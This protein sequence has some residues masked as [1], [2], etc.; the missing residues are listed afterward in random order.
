[1]LSSTFT[2]DQTGQMLSETDPCGNETCTDV[3][4]SSHTTTYSYTDSPVGG[5]APG[6][7]NAYVTKVTRPTTSNIAHTSSYQYSYASGELA[8]STDENSQTTTYLY[9]DP[10][11]RLTDIYGPPSPQNN[12][13]KPHTQYMYTDG[14]GASVT[15][16]NPTN[17]VS[18]SLLDGLGRATET[19]LTKD[20]SGADY[21]DTTYDGMGQ[22]YTVS[23]SYRGQSNLCGSKPDPTC[24][25]TTYSY[26]P[27]GRTT[28]L[29]HPDGSSAITSYSGNTTQLTDEVGN[30]WTQTED[31]LGRL[32]NVAEPGGL[33]TG[34]TYDALG[35]LLTVNQHGTATETPRMRSF[36]YDSLSRLHCASN[37]ENSQ[38]PCPASAATALPVGVTS[39]I[40]DANGNLTS[41]TDGR[42][43]TTGYTYDALNR[44]TT[45]SS[46]G[47]SG[48]PGF[49]YLYGYD[50]ISSGTVQNGIGHL[51]FTT[52]SPGTRAGVAGQYFYDSMGRMTSSTTYLPSAPST[53]VTVSAGYDLAGNETSLTYPDGRKVS[54]VIDG[55]GR[56]SSVNYAAWN[57]TAHTGAYLAVANPG[58]YDAA[59]HLV[60]ATL[61]NGVGIGAGYDNRERISQLVYGSISQMLWGKQYQWTKSSNL[62]SLTDGITGV[63]R[64]FSYD[65]LN[66]LT[67]AQDILGST[68]ETTPPPPSSG[69][70]SG[71]DGSGGATPTPS[72]TDPDDSNVLIDPE[73]PG[74]TGWILNA[75][76][77]VGNIA[78]PDGTT[79]AY[80][81]TASSGSGDSWINDSVTDAYQYTGETMTGSV[82]LRVPNGTQTVNLYLIETGGA[83]G[84]GVS[85]WKP[86]TVTTSWQQFQVSGQFQQGFTGLLLQVG[87]GGTLTSGKTVSL[88]GAMMEDTG[89]TG[90]DVTNFLP[91]SQ[92]FAPWVS[93][94]ITP[95]DNTAIAPDGTNTAATLT[96]S[97]GSTDSHI[98][99]V[100]PNPAAFS[101]QPVTG[102]VWMRSVAGPQN[103]L[104]TLFE[105]GAGDAPGGYSTI[106]SN[107]MA[108]T[109]NWQRF[110]VTGTTLNA[111]TEFLFQIGG[112]GTFTSGSIQVWGA[113]LELAST[114]GP[115]VAT[116]ATAVSTG[117]NLTNLLPY[118][119]QLNGPSWG[120]SSGSI[121]LNAGAAP[122]GTNTAA[123]VTAA[124]GSPDT[125]V[126]D[127]V[128][129]PALYNSQTVTASVYLRV[130]SGTQNLNLYLINV[131]TSSSGPVAMT[132]VT[133]TTTWQRFQVTGTNQNG[134]TRLYLQIGG[135]GTITSGE[136]Y[137]VWGAQIQ[138]GSTVGPYV[139]TSALPVT[140]G[141]DLTNILPNSDG[142]NGPAWSVAN[143]SAAANTATA[144]DGTNTA[145]TLTAAGNSSDTYTLATVPNPSLYDGETVTVSLYARVA[146]GT[147][148]MPLFILNTG[149]N[150]WTAAAETPITLTTTWQRFSVTGTLQNGLT[151]LYMQLGG[152]GAVTSGKSFQVW[153]AQLVVGSDPAPY[154][155]TSSGT[156]NVATS[157]PATLAPNGLNESYSYD[158]F[159]NI[160]QKGSFTA[161][162]TA[163][164]QLV[165]GVYDAA[166]NL[167]SNY[168]SPMTWDAENRLISVGGATYVYDANGN[169]V[170]KQGVGVTDTVYFGGRPVARLSAG[171]WTDLIYGPNGMLGE[172]AGTE[173][174]DTSYRLLDNLG[175]EVGTV[176]STGILTNPLDYT[177]FGQVFSG[178]TNDPYLFTGKERDAESGLDYFGARYYGSSMGRFMSPDWAAQAQPVPYSNLEYPQTLNLY[179][180]AG[181]NPLS[182]SDP[183]GHTWEE[184]GNLVKWGHY[185]NN[186][187]L[188][189][190]LQSDADEARKNISGYTNLSVNGKSPADALK[191]LNN[192]QT[193]NLDRS[194]TNFFEN[195]MMSSGRTQLALAIAT[196]GAEGVEAELA[197]A[198]GSTSSYIINTAKG[199]L[200]KDVTTNVTAAEFGANLEASGFTKTVA[201][202]GVTSLY[203]KGEQT[204]SVYGNS[205]STGGPSANLNV[206]GKIIT[207]I[208]LQ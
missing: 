50:S 98:E 132:A 188:E 32:T 177:P 90:S 45:K 143:G 133:M 158:S 131:G 137:Q 57:A 19:Q 127:A 161:S 70:A 201:K 135:D 6:P 14:V 51:L 23:N 21:V 169:R 159:G 74:S 155:P 125:Y 71:L 5:N 134:L 26:D 193:L 192:Q 185:V 197:M 206:G 48:V 77:V 1:M 9:T 39:Y 120:A 156:T 36:N 15:S 56:V 86:V 33:Q 60:S 149:D 154:T 46:A 96:A 64:Q 115:Y 141:Q 168:L 202:D 93:N 107:A 144:P 65:N 205:K 163:N 150:G 103:I 63:Q 119:Q 27:L 72:W 42:G 20:P 28:L 184:L 101:G 178:S 82:W 85:A 182:R 66:R 84:F 10:F 171:Q 129:N 204:Y 166:G 189:G 79:T 17:V 53:P 124:A 59:G 97:A 138:L 203:T 61:G 153:G 139:A 55:A 40:Y 30:S 123:T 67:N 176:N 198:E 38:N 69:A 128:Q 118:L 95:A 179:A 3:T 29:A 106:G 157:A 140:A 75:G 54:Q 35:N 173:N 113:Q 2:Y 81:F 109:S 16:T 146:S 22:I 100:I 24:N 12:N 148:T 91:Y 160:L 174:A 110:Q 88:W 99:D 34:Y 196:G 183:D 73:T 186:A 105:V 167:L 92:R 194:L 199:A 114:A 89:S 147:L 78:A 190:A 191:G 7:S 47:A 108:L 152:D 165:N 117:T 162:Y 170:E 145:A 80:S 175:T 41:K 104:L 87:A 208:R 11:L 122:D 136:S 130:A 62:Q 8:S 13:V 126:V 102:S 76:A 151:Q 83:N 52:T 181:N 37:P 164:N 25:L 44:M 207:K 111:L 116:G 68:P 18:V 187:G 172:V 195:N 49:N 31:A 142:M 200:A 180:Y 58:G 94:G 121:T 4:G 112:D 43:I